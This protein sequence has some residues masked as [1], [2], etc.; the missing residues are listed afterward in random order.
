MLISVMNI[1]CQGSTQEG[2]P[3]STLRQRARRCSLSCH[4]DPQKSANVPKEAA[5]ACWGQQM[6]G[7]RSLGESCEGQSIKTSGTIPVLKL[8]SD[9]T[10]SKSSSH[11]FW[12]AVCQTKKNLESKI[13]LL[14]TTPQSSQ[15]QLPNPSRTL[16]STKVSSCSVIA[17][18]LIPSSSLTYG[19]KRLAISH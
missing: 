14:K 3:S 17:R 9:A 10:Y 12:R 8:P 19:P 7:A 11:R 2:L 18:T 4:S 5:W 1:R 15:L 13:S 16:L 6:K